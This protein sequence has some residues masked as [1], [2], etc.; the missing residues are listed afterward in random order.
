METYEKAK[1][2]ERCVLGSII[3]DNAR[4]AEVLEVLGERD[5]Y[6]G[7][8]QKIFAAIG[9]LYNGGI[10]VELHTLATRLIERKEFEEIGGQVYLAQLSEVG[11]SPSSAVYYA[12]EVRDEAICRALVR[13]GH[14]IAKDAQDRT[15]SPNDLLDQA[16][17]N[18]L[19]IRETGPCG[20]TMDLPEA[21]DEAADWIDRRQV[22]AMNGGGTDC[23]R[24]GFY[25]LDSL[26]DGLQNSELIVVGARPSHGK[27]SLALCIARNAVL[28]E[29]APV[30]FASI[31]QRRIEL[32]NRLLCGK[33]R[34][35]FQKVRAGNLTRDDAEK[36][37]DAKAA[38][39]R[40]ASF[41]IS[42]HVPQTMMRITAN[43]RRLKLRKGLRLAMVDYLQIVS[44]DQ[45][46]PRESRYEQISETSR[47]LK[48][49]ARELGIPVLALAQ[50]NRDAE[51]RRPRLSD[52]KE[53]GQIEQDADVVLLLYKSQEKPGIIEVDVA[54]QRNAATGRIELAFQ[55]EFMNFENNLP[56]IFETNGQ[57]AP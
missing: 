12:K 45:R 42:D 10:P 27:T 40:G 1:E 22:Q 8:H 18:I 38:F 34:V 54:K 37:N 35:S 3:R 11:F 29:N 48:A 39:L 13:A 49:L 51:D 56:G 25:E 2:A 46:N 4:F 26:L 16:E 7:A 21:L 19:A 55:A 36:L 23:V 30:F 14:E 20:E 9:E 5:F 15:G 43:A 33:A 31:E 41:T 17:R 53:S 44:P 6:S 32:V 57:A 52:L 50:L 28:Q 24:T 47:R